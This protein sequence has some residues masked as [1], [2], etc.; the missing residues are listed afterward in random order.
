MQNLLPEEKEAYNISRWASQNLKNFQGLDKKY[1]EFFKKHKKFL[2]DNKDYDLSDS[3]EYKS[4]LE[5][6]KPKVDLKR[7]EREMW[8]DEAEKRAIKE[9]AA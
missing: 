7:I 4:F 9:N 5:Q 6:N 8:T 2:D 1:I 3:D